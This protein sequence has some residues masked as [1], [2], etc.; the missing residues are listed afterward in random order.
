LFTFYARLLEFRDSFTL[1]LDNTLLLNHSFLSQENASNITW[2]HPIGMLQNV[3]ALKAGF[4]YQIQIEYQHTNTNSSMQHGLTLFWD[5]GNGI[6][7][8]EPLH[9]FPADHT[10]E[11]VPHYF[12]VGGGIGTRLWIGGELVLGSSQNEENRRNS[13]PLLLHP[14]TLYEVRLEYR[15]IGASN[16]FPNLSW[17]TDINQESISIPSNLLWSSFSTGGDIMGSP[18]LVF[19]NAG[20]ISTKQSEFYSRVSESQVL[21]GQHC[22]FAILCKDSSGNRLSGAA[23]LQDRFL[24]VLRHNISNFYSS[25]LNRYIKTETRNINAPVLCREDECVASVSTTKAGLHSVD[26][27]LISEGG[28]RVTDYAD[29]SFQLIKEEDNS[30][31]NDFTFARWSGFLKPSMRS[32]YTFFI[33]LNRGYER[34]KLWID[35]VLIVDQWSSVASLEANGT[36]TLDKDLFYEIDLRYQSFFKQ[37]FTSH[38]SKLHWSHSDFLKKPIP[39]SFLFSSTQIGE[40]FALSVLPYVP[41]V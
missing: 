18:Y 15:K 20:S 10:A 30:T 4:F 7:R 37:N 23:L 29:S 28:L 33:F 5:F 13:S 32:N 24:V 21:V 36:C 39:L 38:Q 35:S 34:A 27:N 9:L 31:Q 22:E 40:N 19:V 26:V 17:K 2:V 11:L 6:R 14:E 16:E 8:I 25:Y 41:Q 12:Y 3:R 1:W